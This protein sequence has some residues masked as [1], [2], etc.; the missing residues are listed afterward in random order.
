VTLAA[1]IMD[2]KHPL[3]RHKTTVRGRYDAALAEAGKI[4][5]CFD[6]LFFNER[7]ELTE[8]ARSTVYLVRDGKWLTPALDC[9]LLD[10]VMRRELLATHQPHI[11]EAQ[12]SRADLLSADEIWLSNALRGLFRVRLLS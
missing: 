8:G 9:G 3:L 4:P 11:E 6:A 10:A 5:G 1:A 2:S 12:L 7:G